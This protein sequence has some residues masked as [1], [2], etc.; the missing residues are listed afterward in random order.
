MR[1]LD[2]EKSVFASIAD[3]VQEKFPEHKN[4]AQLATGVC[5]CHWAIGWLNEW[6]HL[7]DRAVSFW[8]EA[9]RS[10]Q[11]K[12][13]TEVDIGSAL[14]KL[15]EKRK[16]LETEL[17]KYANTEHHFQKIIWPAT[18]LQWYAKEETTASDAAKVPQG[19]HK[20]TKAEE[21]KGRK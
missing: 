12:E 13:G 11:P 9:E 18:N 15:Q 7:V 10:L 14:L 8:N 16:R 3:R 6:I 4:P 17:H 19:I 1:L 5:E 2:P 20:G 21:G